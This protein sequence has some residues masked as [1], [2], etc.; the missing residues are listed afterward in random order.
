MLHMLLQPLSLS[1]KRST[2]NHYL[3]QTKHALLY[4]HNGNEPFKLVIVGNNLPWTICTDHNYNYYKYIYCS[5][6]ENVFFHIC[7]C[8]NDSEVYKKKANT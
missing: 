3:K 7:A 5:K 2:K 1:K 4:I 6:K 8:V